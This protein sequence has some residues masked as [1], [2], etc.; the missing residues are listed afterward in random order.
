M[1]CIAGMW[2]IGVAFDFRIFYHSY[3]F[4]GNGKYVTPDNIPAK[5]YLNIMIPT[6]MK[7]LETH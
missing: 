4:I 3:K 1:K 7:Y 5:Q 2:E 6:V